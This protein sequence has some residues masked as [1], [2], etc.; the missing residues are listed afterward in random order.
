[1]T[2]GE[3]QA[4]FTRSLARLLLHMEALGLE[5]RIK[6]VKRC[7]DCPVGHPD[8]THKSALAADI[9]LFKDGE[10]L[11]KTADYYDCGLYW[12][13]L[14]SEHSWGGHFDDGNHYSILHNG[15]R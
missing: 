3:K 15:V 8:S 10:Y 12:E 5:A 11:T 13:S 6:F 1:M 14:G 4:L 9:D 7:D 2:L